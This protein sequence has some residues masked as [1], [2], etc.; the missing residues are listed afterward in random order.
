[1][2]ASMLML[3]AEDARA[4]DVAGHVSQAKFF[5]KKGWYPD[6]LKEL[7][8]AAALPDGAIDPEVW[9]LIATVRYALLDVAGAS[10][11]AERAQ[12][13]ARDDDQLYQAASY[14]QFLREQFGEVE[15]VPPY[16]GFAGKLDLEP[17]FPP[18]DPEL[19]AFLGRLDAK[20]SKKRTFPVVLSLPIG[21]YQ[22]NGEPVTVVAGERVSVT[23]SSSQLAGSGFANAQ[24]AKF[25][26]GV[27]FANW[28]GPQ[29]ANL[30]PSVSLHG[31]VTQPFAGLLAGVFV[32]WA[33]TWY[34]SAQGQILFS[35]EGWSVGA[36]LGY[37]LANSG[38][39]VIRPSLGWRLTQI[40]GVERSCLSNGDGFTCTNDGP[41]ELI[42]YGTG[43]ANVA[44]AELSIDYIDRSRKR[45]LGIGVKV[46]GEEAFG[47]LPDHGVARLRDGQGV[48]FVLAD[49]ARGFT[50]T[51][52]RFMPN[53]SI[54][55]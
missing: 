31:A 39:L 14:A 41:A 28:F 53:V 35:S 26:L 30:Q 25:E 49:D 46:I 1:M 32:D 52:F 22:L 11:A 37:E 5:L 13:F 10:D 34:D 33:P 16:P 47:R 4:D 2:I 44:L 17:V 40:P 15:V 21:D 6:A 48:D 36:R 29:V 3:W 50:A 42:V 54:A 12:T 8:G 19:R 24:L 23:R 55:F 7:E 45:T 27:G 51:G 43:L 9:Y 38:A 20:T 18:I